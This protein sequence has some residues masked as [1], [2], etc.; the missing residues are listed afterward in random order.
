M[1]EKVYVCVC[2]CVWVR[3][4]MRACVCVCEVIYHPKILID[5]VIIIFK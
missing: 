1:E 3:A 5:K 4:C 2:V